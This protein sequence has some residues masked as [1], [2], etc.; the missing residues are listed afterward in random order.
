[1]GMQQAGVQ[2]AYQLGIHNHLNDSLG[3]LLN[4]YSRFGAYREALS[5]AATISLDNDGAKTNVGA[6]VYTL[7]KETRIL[8]ITDNFQKG[9]FLISFQMKTNTAPNAVQAKVYIN[10]LPVSIEFSDVTGG[11]VLK[12]HTLA[13]TLYPG[14]KVQVW[15]KDVLSAGVSVINLR[16]SFGWRIAG[17]GDGTSRV[18]TVPLAVTDADNPFT[19]VNTDP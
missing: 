15:V 2:A 11:Y 6:G 17:F 10:D 13:G 4:A 12:S 9:S 1:M 8:T 7:L 3:G 18:L 19:T 5:T 14:D 16:I